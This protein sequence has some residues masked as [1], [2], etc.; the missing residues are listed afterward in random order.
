MGKLNHSHTPTLQLRKEEAQKSCGEE[1]T[2]N[3]HKGIDKVIAQRNFFTKETE[4]RNLGGLRLESH[5]EE[6]RRQNFQKNGSL[7]AKCQYMV[8]ETWSSILFHLPLL[9]SELPWTR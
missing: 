1:G 3:S 7:R 6:N 8:R 2:Q 9:C 4:M 5:T